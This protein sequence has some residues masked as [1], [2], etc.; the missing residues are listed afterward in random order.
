MR[1]A[2]WILALAAVFLPVARAL[3]AGALEIDDDLFASRRVFPSIGPGLRALRRGASGNYYVLASPSVG[4]DIFDAKGKSLSVIGAPAPASV[5]DKAERP[6]IAFG[7]DCDVDAQGN[8]YVADAGS[9]LVNEFA[10]DGKQL[11]S[12]PV[13]SVI[14]LAVLPEGEVAVTTRESTHHVT[15]YG[16]DGKMAREFGD[17]ESLSSRADID[18]YLNLGRVASDPQG[19][20]Y[21]GFTY[22]PEPLVRQYDRYGN[23]TQDFVFT[24]VDAYP[25]AS[26]TRKAIERQEAKAEPLVFHPILTAYGVDPVSGDIWMGLHNTL[27]HFDKD[28]VR[29]SEYQI[30]T[31]KGSPLDATVILVEEERLLIGNDPLGVYEFHRPDRKH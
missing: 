27:V 19:H 7:E 12:F 14:S 28:G 24:G 13:N 3:R 26:T 25:E 30:Y 6:A 10:P 1:K 15:V 20:I 22:M 2:I 17:I 8:V 21:Y 16:T 4:L 5:T 29:R 31:P 23:A 11:R 18:R 9:N